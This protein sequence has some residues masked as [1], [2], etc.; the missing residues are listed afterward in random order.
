MF[1]NRVQLANMMLVTPK[2][3]TPAQ[4]KSYANCVS[5]GL[6]IWPPFR[7]LSDRLCDWFLVF[8]TPP[9]KFR[10]GP[11]VSSVLKSDLFFLITARATQGRQRLHNFKEI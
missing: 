8:N 1:A 11:Y 5:L 9:R 3:S 10:V 2:S 7:I 6:R 4:T